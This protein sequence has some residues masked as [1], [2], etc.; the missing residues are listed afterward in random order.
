M[1]T[2]MFVNVHMLDEKIDVVRQRLA[3]DESRR[4]AGRLE[5]GPLI[6]PQERVP[7]WNEVLNLFARE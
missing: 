2:S 6:Q 4:I 7:V 1:S 5:Q 3:C